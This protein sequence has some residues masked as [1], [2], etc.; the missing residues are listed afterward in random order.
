MEYARIVKTGL[1]FGGGFS[2]ANVTGGQPIHPQTFSHWSSQSSS[3]STASVTSVPRIRNT[4]KK[5]TTV[6]VAINRVICNI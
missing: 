1:F 5:K 2:N 6:N 4:P 3:Q